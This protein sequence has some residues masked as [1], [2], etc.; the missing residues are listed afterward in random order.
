MTTRPSIEQIRNVG[1]FTQM[2]RWNV[3]FEKFPNLVSGPGSEAINFRAE[4]V[5]IPKLDPNA[6]EINLRGHKV[7]QPGIATYGNQITLTCVETVDNIIAQFIHDWREKCWESDNGGTG[8][9]HYKSELEA[10]ILITRLDNMDQPIWIYK[11]FGCFLETNEAGG[12]LGG[13]SADPLKPQ[14]VLSFDYFNDKPMTA[15]KS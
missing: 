7:K 8:K 1:N 10:T 3:E 12:D 2:F 14:L 15:S 11:L 4:S 13:D 5:T 9:T 6:V